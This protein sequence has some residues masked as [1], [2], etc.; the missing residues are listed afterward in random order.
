VARRRTVNFSVTIKNTGNIVWS[1]ATITIKIYRPDGNLAATQAVS[2]KGIQ[3][4]SQYTY[5]INW[6]VPYN[7]PR[8]IWH[9][10]VYINYSDVLI[11]S[12]TNP[13]NTIK[14]E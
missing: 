2:V 7:A 9:Y 3:P 1:S 13:A 14:V 6:R 8:G 10:E 5:R 4:G 11:A 12:S